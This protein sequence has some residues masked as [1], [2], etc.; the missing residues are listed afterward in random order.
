MITKKTIFL[1]DKNLTHITF[2]GNIGKVQNLENIII[3]FSRLSLKIAS[4]AQLN[5]IGDGSNL[6]HLKKRKS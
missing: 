1:G 5:I 3:A 6:N 4:K 2:A